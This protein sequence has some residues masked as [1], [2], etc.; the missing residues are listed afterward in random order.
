L[1]DTQEVAGSIPARPTTRA[2]T[3]IGP[4]IAVTHRITL[5]EV[6]SPPATEIGSL[7]ALRES[8]RRSLLAGNK[9]P[10]TISAY[11]GAVDRLGIFLDA[12][13]MPTQAASLTREHIETFIAGVLANRKPATAHQ[14]YRGL[15]AFFKWA[16]EEGEIA[17]SP[18]RNMSP[19]ILPEQPVP[20]LTDDE[21]EALIKT[22]EGKSFEDRRDL[23]IIRLFIASG[24]RRGELAGL[25][26]SDI[27]F[28]Y[29]AALVM[30]KGRRPR[31]APFGPKT[32]V[33]LDRYLRARASHKHA[34][35]PA[36]WLGQRGQMTG[37]GIEQIVGKRGR[38]ARIE[39]LHPHQ[40]RHQFAHEWLSLGGAEGDLMQIAGWRSRQ[41]LGRYAASAANE[42]A[43]EAHKRLSPG[44]RF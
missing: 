31:S 6:K 27:D 4:C 7:S 40:L 10:Q 2:Y 32:A 20:L 38:K 26:V 16:L 25:H 44:E 17:E 9:S 36:L 8:F 39:G 22:C 15:Q 14:R 29:N 41:M 13:G 5:T 33:A 23:A 30:G 34:D 35:S 24:M 21:L 18:M 12:A 42:R 1:L 37:W 19:P 3:E 28:D 11:C 43:R